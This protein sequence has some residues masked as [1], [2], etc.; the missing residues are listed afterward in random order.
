MDE[1]SATLAMSIAAFVVSVVAL[2]L[3]VILAVL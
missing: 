3:W 2:T 1:N